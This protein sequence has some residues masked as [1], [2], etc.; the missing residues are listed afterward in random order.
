MNGKKFDHPIIVPETSTESNSLNIVIIVEVV[1]VVK[2]PSEKINIMTQRRP[3][4]GGR[5]RNPIA[6]PDAQMQVT[7][8]TFFLEWTHSDTMLKMGVPAI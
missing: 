2:N 8:S 5:Q 7:H 3:V 1:P 4:D 6:N